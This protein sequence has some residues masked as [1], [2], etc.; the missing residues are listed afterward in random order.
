MAIKTAHITN[1]YHRDSGGISTSFNKLLE[2][3]NAQR[4]HAILIVPGE[5]DDV[6]QVG[7][8]AR[9]YYVR[10]PR[11]P[12]FDRRYR[13]MLPWKAYMPDGSPVK[14]ILREEK[15]DIIEIGEKYSLS[16]M[17][18]L[19]RT[20]QVRMT[21]PRPILVHSS[22]ERM[23]DNVR[24]FLSRGSL[25]RWLSR[26]V[27]GHHVTPMFDFHIANSQYTLNE[28]IDASEWSLTRSLIGRKCNS[29]WRSPSIGVAARSFTNNKGADISIF[30]PERRSSEMRKALSTNFSIQENAKILLYAG[31]LSPEKNAGLLIETAKQLTSSATNFRFLILGD[32]PERPAFEKLAERTCP[33]RFVF[34]GHIAERERLADILAN[35]DAFVHPNP[36]EPFGIA[37]LEAMA[38]GLP[39]VAPNAGGVLSYAN[40]KNAWL[41]EPDGK[42]FA[43]AAISA[44]TDPVLIRERTS[45]ALE[46]AAKFSWERSTGERFAIY[47]EIY[48]T[49]H[50]NPHLYS[51][52]ATDQADPRTFD[53]RKARTGQHPR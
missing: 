37:P 15:P 1:Y 3:A 42:S 38:S 33:G 44:T 39:V 27:I 26:A 32:G 9:I 20:G 6:E 4:R 18:G 5:K 7:E 46:T 23:V 34:T 41:A 47:D 14:E 11:S 8:F 19:I 48:E 21:R 22:C 36:R 2:A 45:S 29:L 49:Y 28:L 51:G 52:T 17:A 43:K 16:L 30:S 50:A 13:L 40:E 10:S 31:R 12:F 53:L 24:A 35:G 25:G